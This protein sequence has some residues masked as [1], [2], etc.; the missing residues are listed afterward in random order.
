MLPDSSNINPQALEVIQR[1]N[2]DLQDQVREHGDRL[3]AAYQRLSEEIAARESAERAR[4]HLAAVVESADDAIISKTLDGI[5][6]SWNPGAERLFGYRAEEMIAEPVTRIIP[7]ENIREEA[8]I[9]ARLKRGE[10]I[11][12][13][14]AV[15]RRKDSTLIPVSLTIS[16]VRDAAGNII[17]ASK[18]ARDLTDRKNYEAQAT[19]VVQLQKAL[20]EIKTLRGLIPIC[21]W[22]KRIRDDKAFWH[23]VEQYISERTEA[24]FTHGICPGCYERV[25][26]TE[27]PSR[28]ERGTVD[29]G[30]A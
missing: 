23:T 16:P 9:L 13:Y 28:A 3:L 29:D 24:T 1:L 15:R 25:V 17:G 8:D 11:D 21:A 4:A 7:Q 20:A 14:E 18:I 2:A 22:C 26:A 27:L 5:V 6:R 10:R 19:L 30:G 12:H